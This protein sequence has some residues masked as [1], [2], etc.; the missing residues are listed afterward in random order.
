[1]STLEARDISVQRGGRCILRQ[2]S[3]SLAPGELRAVIG[4]NG[5][6]KSTLLRALAGI[7]P[8]AEG[9]VW[10]DGEPIAR[11]PR[12][13]I[14]RRIAYVPQEQRVDFAFTVEQIV[15][16][17]RHPHREGSRAK[18]SMTGGPWNSL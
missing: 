3:V 17:G 10:L 2:A 9:G 16:M 12:R 14:A 15:A 5:G 11:W 7:W 13:E 6:G 4:P 1:M 8:V 18:P